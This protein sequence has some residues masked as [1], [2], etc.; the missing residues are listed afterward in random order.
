MLHVYCNGAAEGRSQSLD[1][2]WN[3]IKGND[4]FDSADDDKSNQIA[5]LDFRLNMQ[6]LLQIPVGIY[7]Q[8]VGE[9]EAGFLP[10]KKCI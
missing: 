3:A 10:A 7:G 5:G 2:L 1:S 8:Y 4:N 9:D 6:P